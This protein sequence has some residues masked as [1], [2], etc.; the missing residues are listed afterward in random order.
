[1]VYSYFLFK[2]KTFE[3]KC[4]CSSCLS[5]ILGPWQYLN[6]ACEDSQLFRVLQ[7]RGDQVGNW[8]K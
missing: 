5:T 2:I 7:G 8:K 3:D 1:M 4:D 6:L